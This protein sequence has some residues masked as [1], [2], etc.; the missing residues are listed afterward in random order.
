MPTIIDGNMMYYLLKIAFNLIYST[1]ESFSLK[2]FMSASD[3]RKSTV[4]PPFGLG[5][6]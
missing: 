6:S 3:M 2:S 5:V 4:G 1:C